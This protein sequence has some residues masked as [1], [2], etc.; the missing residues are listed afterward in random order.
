MTIMTRAQ[1]WER[2]DAICKA[3]HREYFGAYVKEF[4]IR[5]PAHLIPMCREALAAGD[6]HMNSPFT[7]LKDWDQADYI[8]R[9]NP[10]LQSALKANGEGWSPS[11]NICLLKEAARQQIEREDNAD[12]H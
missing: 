9:G 12:A 10:F 6:M 1:F 7:S 11:V 4:R 8:T 2:H 3:L 5:A